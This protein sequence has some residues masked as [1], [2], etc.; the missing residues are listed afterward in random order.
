MGQRRSDTFACFILAAAGFSLGE[1][2]EISA[3]YGAVELCSKAMRRLTIEE[4]FAEA[5]KEGPVV[6]PRGRCTRVR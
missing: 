2:V 1:E 4:M 6:F 5:E 3:S